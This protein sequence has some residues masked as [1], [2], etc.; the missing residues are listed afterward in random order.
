MSEYRAYL[1]PQGLRIEFDGS[2]GPTHLVVPIVF[3]VG[4]HCWHNLSWMR[5]HQYIMIL[6]NVVHYPLLATENLVVGKLLSKT[7]N[8]SIAS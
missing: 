6:F 1:K 8:N 2:H 7:C 3:P 4:I 5:I